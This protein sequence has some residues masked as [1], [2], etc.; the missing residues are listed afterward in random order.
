MADVLPFLRETQGGVSPGTGPVVTSEA[1]R[2]SL[3]AGDIAS[4]YQMLGHMLEQ[5]GEGLGRAAEAGAAGLEAVAQPLAEKAGLQAV[6]R[7]DQGNLQVSKAPIVGQA[8]AVYARALKFSAL[9]QGEAEAKRQDIE[10]SKQFPDDPEKYLSASKSYRDNLVNDYTQKIGP[11]VG[12]SLGRSIDNTTTQNYRWML[13]KQQQR[14]KE[15][16]DRDTAAS[17][18]DKTEDLFNLI[19]TGGAGTPDARR[20]VNGIISIHNE[21][22]N[23][24][25]LGAPAEATKLELKDLDEKVGAAKFVYGINQ[26]LKAGN[27]NDA[28]A[29]VD[30]VMNDN[31]LSPTQRVINH[32]HGLAA[33][34]D[35][36]QN[37]ERSANIA[38]KQ[39]K[40]KDEL[41]EDAVV[42][43]TA[44]DKPL[45][46]NEIKNSDASPESRIRMINFVKRDGMTEPPARVSQLAAMGLFQRMNLP[47]DDPNK[48]TSLNPIRDAYR[49]GGPLRREEED[50][51]EKKF[52]EGRSPD[53]SQLNKERSEVTKAAALD[54]SS[55]MRIDDT[56]KMAAL[57]Y[58][59]YIDQRIDDYRREKKNPHD[60]FNPFNKDFIG[61]PEITEFFRSTMQEQMDNISRKYSGTKPPPPPGYGGAP[62]IVQPPTPKAVPQRQPGESLADF[63]KRMGLR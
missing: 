32:M 20:L 19:A 7:D 16:F 57:R 36:T 22:V 3:S 5:R 9:A 30:D 24:P 40:Q 41:F 50:W 12:L 13:L 29:Q 35:F 33:I 55:L 11:E 38:A 37:N 47:D 18:K 59:K 14:I 23:N 54:K 43:S 60:L 15:N 21:R 56:G 34:K 48:I 39:Q 46:E 63:D 31:S 25:V 45:T 10:L 49:P 17:I 27:I 44:T 28:L 8:G 2:S 58:E 61:K 52:I 1:P 62:A 42:R 53:G 4:P 26:T 51:L 6:S